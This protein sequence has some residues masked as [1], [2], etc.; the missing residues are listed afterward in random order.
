[1]TAENVNRLKTDMGRELFP[2]HSVTAGDSKL[3]PAPKH[4]QIFQRSVTLG[5]GAITQ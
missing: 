3:A 1:M 2:R 5:S 4:V